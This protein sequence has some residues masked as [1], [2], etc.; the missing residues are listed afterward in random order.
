MNK[1]LF[2]Q[3]YDKSDSHW[4]IK[5]YFDILYGDGY[6]LEVIDNIVKKIGFCCD[7][8][9][10]NFPDMN[11]YYEE[12]HF[13]GVEFAWGYPPEEDDTIIVSEE[14]CFSYVRLA[15]EKYL[16]LH[17][18]DSAKVSTLLAQLP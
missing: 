17:P 10:C 5:G 8:A 16:Q 12:E 6:F 14:A 9:Y 18:E 11:S 3:P 1:E 7:G 15:C 13:E 4:I 2:G